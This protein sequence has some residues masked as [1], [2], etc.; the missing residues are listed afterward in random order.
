MS[1]ARDDKRVEAL[2]AEREHMARMIRAVDER[3]AREVESMSQRYRESVRD[4]SVARGEGVRSPERVRPV[5]SMTSKPIDSEPL[6]RRRRNSSDDGKTRTPSSSRRTT[7][8]NDESESE[9]DGSESSPSSRALVISDKRRNAKKKK[10]IQTVR[11]EHSKN[12]R[13]SPASPPDSEISKK[14][15]S[16][17]SA[18]NKVLRHP[19][20]N[21][22]VEADDP[23][24]Q[25]TPPSAQPSSSQ[26]TSRRPRQ[27]N[28]GSADAEEPTAAENAKINTVQFRHQLYVKMGVV[29]PVTNKTDSKL[30][31][32]RRQWVL[33]ECLGRGMRLD[34][35]FK[36]YPYETKMYPSIKTIHAISPKEWGWNREVVRDIIRIMCWDRV[37]NFRARDRALNP[38]SIPPADP[39]RPVDRRT[40]RGKKRTPMSGDDNTTAGKSATGARVKSHQSTVPARIEVPSPDAS[41]PS[42]PELPIEP[43]TP[44]KRAPS[45]PSARDQRM[46]SRDPDIGLSTAISNDLDDGER[47]NTKGKSNGKSIPVIRSTRQKATILHSPHDTAVSTEPLADLS[48][49]PILIS[50]ILKYK[51]GKPLLPN[52]PPGISQRTSLETSAGE[53]SGEKDIFKVFMGKKIFRFANDIDWEEFEHEIH[54][55]VTLEAGEALFYRARGGTGRDKEWKPLSYAVEMEN[56]I[57]RFAHCGAEVCV[58]ESRVFIEEE[59]DDSELYS[60]PDLVN[61]GQKKV[62]AEKDRDGGQIQPCLDGSMAMMNINGSQVK[63]NVLDLTTT[64]TKE[65]EKNTAAELAAGK[66]KI[67]EEKKKVAEEKKKKAAE[68]KKRVAEEKNAK[69]RKETDDIADNQPVAKKGR[70]RPRKNANSNMTTDK[71]KNSQLSGSQSPTIAKSTLSHVEVPASP[72]NVNNIDPNE[73]EKSIDSASV[74]SEEA[75][76]TDSQIP[77]N[78]QRRS[79]R[80]ITKSMRILYTEET[81]KIVGEANQLKSAKKDWKNEWIEFERANPPAYMTSI[82]ATNGEG[83][84]HMNR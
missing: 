23:A 60:K 7:A 5:A 41:Y 9:Q 73:K 17:H 26:T 2:K 8:G 57:R 15:Q 59:D 32:A 45:R 77:N 47:L 82:M 43:D 61:G 27:D 4:D 70:G 20:R 38:E 66:K 3:L 16:K 21:D 25:S 67:A 49:P 62:P 80:K 39:N 69:K 42:E 13:S 33:E 56:M 6:M 34:C 81:Q 65:T 76:I 40:L 14:Q 75:S 84:L 58:K 12:E 19:R 18:A 11:F 10:A 53:S 72:D 48:S 37:R 29:D 1:S 44:Q 54:S 22:N 63:V 83:A 31:R 64:M 36:S 68:D 24:S 79:G 46:E 55:R 50:P 35:T 78:S 71:F 51:K 30:L 74:N 28:R 52:F